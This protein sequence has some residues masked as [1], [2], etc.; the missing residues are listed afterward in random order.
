MRI[1]QALFRRKHMPNGHIYKGKNRL[2]KEPQWEDVQKLRN[3]FAIE[4]ENM[5][6][7]RHAYL[8]P[9]SYVRPNYV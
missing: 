5:F 6:Y 2:Y 4:E 8:T 3:Q 1:F 9:V 7:L